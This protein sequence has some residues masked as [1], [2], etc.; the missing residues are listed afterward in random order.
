MQV[1]RGLQRGPSPEEFPSR[2]AIGWTG[3]IMATMAT[4]ECRVHQS[5]QFIRLAEESANSTL[6]YSSLGRV[7][8]IHRG[9]PLL[10]PVW[11]ACL[12]RLAQ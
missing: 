8:L 2:I 3:S 9:L 10:L 1:L 4:E 11:S 12:L 7:I 5:H 6:S